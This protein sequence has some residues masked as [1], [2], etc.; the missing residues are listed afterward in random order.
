MTDALS[1][2]TA[3]FK[4][5]PGIGP[6]QASRFVYFLLKQDRG[7]LEYFANLILNLK[8]DVKQCPDC[9]RFFAIGLQELC[10]ECSD[11]NRVSAH[12][13]IIE[14]DADLE[15]ARRIPEYNGKFFV[16]GGNV[17]ILEDQPEK[18]IRLQQLCTRVSRDGAKLQEII[19]ALSAT[20]EGDYTT[21]LIKDA[22]QDLSKTHNI[23]ITMLGRGLSTGTEIE[24]I[25]PDTMSAA[26]RNRA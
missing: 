1:R 8:R 19:L 22:L 6:R 15:N 23:T 11:D 18:L 4:R 2:L 9:F 10:T 25:D 20:R 14:K 12:L 21:T 13:L 7:T 24:Y 16:L 26:L 17:P 3:F 5:F